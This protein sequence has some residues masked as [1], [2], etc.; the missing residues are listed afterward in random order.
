ML[1]SSMQ[2][3]IA[4]GDAVR[5]FAQERIRPH[6]Q[7]FEAQGGYPPELFRELAELGLM[8]TTAPEGKGGA[9]AE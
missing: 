1:L 5:A 2:Q 8:A 9:G 7:R 3:A 6:T 4:I